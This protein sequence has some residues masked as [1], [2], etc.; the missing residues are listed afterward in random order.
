MTTTT[1]TVPTVTVPTVAV[2]TVTG[3]GT[4]GLRVR[5]LDT[6]DSAAVL[7]VFAGLGTRSRELRFMVPKARLTDADL[8]QLTAVD[9]H[10]HVAVVASTT[11]DDRPVGIAR[12]VRD[13]DYP[14]SAEVAVAVVDQWQGRGVGTMLLDGLALRAVEVGVR[15]FT[16]LVSPDNAAILQM[17]QR[18]AGFTRV[19]VDRWTVQYVV[20]LEGALP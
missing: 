14:D 9:D 10:D 12:F 20:P 7:A 15:R 3:Q 6:G 18:T 16:A 19:A 5:P 11:L 1:V 2:P 8:R 13:P 4:R 17:L